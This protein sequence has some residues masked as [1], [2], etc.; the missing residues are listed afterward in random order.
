MDYF[1]LVQRFESALFVSLVCHGQHEDWF[2]ASLDWDFG[3]T[4]YRYEGHRHQIYIPDSRRLSELIAARPA[5]ARYESFR[6]RCE[7]ACDRLFEA[8]CRAR[9]AFHPEMGRQEVFGLLAPVLEAELAAMPFLPSL[10]LIQNA[11][12]HDLREALSADLGWDPGS[13]EFGAFWQSA[14]VPSEQPDFVPETRDVLQLARRYADDGLPP[15]LDASAL[16]PAWRTAI[17]DH[18]DT[19]G[20]LG[21]FTYLNDPYDETDILRRVQAASAGGRDGLAETLERSRRELAEAQRAMARVRDDA[22]R[23]LL[24]QTRTYMRLRFERVDV[25]FKTE[26][27]TRALQERLAQLAGI[28]RSQLVM[29]TLDELRAWALAGADLPSGAELASREECGIDYFVE[30]GAHRWNVAEPLRRTIDPAARQAAETTGIFGDTACVGAV[31]GRIKHVTSP[32]DMKGFE[33]GD[34]L[35][36]PMTT[37][38]VMYALERAAGIVTDEGGVLCHAAIIS[39]ELNKPC[40]IACSNATSAFGDGDVVQLEADERGGVVRLVEEGG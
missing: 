36:T 9:D 30:D 40:V 19:Y 38:D 15:D 2:R 34:I 27:Q 24:E 23:T 21:T 37:P 39:R 6:A 32:T 4:R 5:P 14:V 35:L 22:A 20:W 12:E 10:V 29:L 25:H 1:P 33:E 7:A 11:I 18:I 17:A 13:A 31:R 28:P 16:P 3:V 8:G 26:V